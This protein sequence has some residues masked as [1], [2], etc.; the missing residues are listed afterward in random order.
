MSLTMDSLN[1]TIVAPVSPAKILNS[2]ISD[3]ARFVVIDRACS[4]PAVT[5]A[6]L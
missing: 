2:S 5:S 6:V 4:W 1:S 3:L